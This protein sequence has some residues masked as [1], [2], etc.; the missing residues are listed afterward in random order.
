MQSTTGFFGD[1][2]A[3]D[4]RDTYYFEAFGNLN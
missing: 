2:L 3:A 4:I 1:E